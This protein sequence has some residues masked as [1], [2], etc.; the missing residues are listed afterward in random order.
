[1]LS[2]N[3]IFTW[4]SPLGSSATV[5]DHPQRAG[6]IARGMS[7]ETWR[8]CG[9]QWTRSIDA[10]QDLRGLPRWGCGDRADASSI[11]GNR[12]S[13][14]RRCLAV[15]RGRRG[16]LGQPPVGGRGGPRRWQLGS[17]LGTDSW[18]RNWQ[19]RRDCTRGGSFASETDW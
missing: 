9:R 12:Q 6:D 7:R 2:I 10:C 14:A 3:A 18:S 11:G 1:V 15:L 8:S 4:R 13:R 17:R 19:R 16:E 5:S